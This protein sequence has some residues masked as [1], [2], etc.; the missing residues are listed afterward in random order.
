MTPQL[1]RWEAKLL[2]GASPARVGEPARQRR[3]SAKADSASSLLRRCNYS[4][5]AAGHQ[6]CA[7]ENAAERFH[8]REALLANGRDVAADAAEDVGSAATSKAAGDFLLGLDHAQI[9]FGQVVV[10]GDPEIVHEGQHLIG[11]L[12]K[13]QHEV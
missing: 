12:L 1:Q 4:A 5:T 7:G 3:L 10:E 11:A 9:P 6:G 13:A 8:E 2:R